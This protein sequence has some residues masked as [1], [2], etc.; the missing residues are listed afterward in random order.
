MITDPRKGTRR[1][2]DADPDWFRKEVRRMARVIQEQRLVIQMHA[3]EIAMR[4][5]RKELARLAAKQEAE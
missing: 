4:D 2:T 5:L 1:A 3:A